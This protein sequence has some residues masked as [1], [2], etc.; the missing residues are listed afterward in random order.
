MRIVLRCLL[1]ISLGAAPAVGLAQP[2]RDTAVAEQLFNQGRDLVK[3]GKHA[4]ACPKFEASLRYD[5]VL[6]TRLN[7][8]SCYAEIGKLASAWGLYRESIELAAKAGD[9]KRSDFARQ[10]AAALEPRLPRLAITVPANAPLKLV[11][12]RGSATL[13]AAEF[14]V[15][16]IA[17]PGP[18][19]VT[20]KAP[21]FADFTQTI[22]L[23]EGK[24]EMLAIPRLTL[25]AAPP[26][27][28]PVAL[29]ASSSVAEARSG[30]SRLRTYSALGLGAAGAVAATAG[31]LFGIKAKS[32]YDE[33]K[34]LCGDELKC[35]PQRL[36][37][38]ER[39]VDDARGSATAATVLILA[40]SAAIV[41]GGVLYLTAPDVR[42]AERE[43]EASASRTKRFSPRLTPLVEPS[44]VGLVFTGGF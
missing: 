23:V 14:G 29:P 3:A 8:A 30:R 35:P 26:V 15:A 41:A 25:V 28:T 32:S 1:A 44:A 42:D 38:G 43:S 2:G 22:T 36:R 5:P 18:V 33:A 34:S 10:Q 17:D 12:T 40:G 16:V 31:F 39:L 7:L 19:T 11:V 37:E 13:D 20:A 4:D 24:T 9:T 6:G 27:H 21:G